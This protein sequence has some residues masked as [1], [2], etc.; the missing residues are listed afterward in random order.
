MYVYDVQ[1]VS[2]SCTNV[3][4]ALH[5]RL[6]LSGSVGRSGN[7]DRREHPMLL[8]VLPPGKDSD[9]D[10][11]PPPHQSSPPARRRP[12]GQECDGDVEES[13][14]LRTPPPRPPPPSN[15]KNISRRW[16]P[17]LPFFPLDT[18]PPGACPTVR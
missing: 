6:Q 16:S 9:H 12:P 14:L 15:K 10:V 17:P 11:V 3:G 1:K 5:F 7:G 8:P 18:G 4:N 13:P 2:T